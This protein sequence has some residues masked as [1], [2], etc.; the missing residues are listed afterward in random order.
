MPPPHTSTVLPTTL[1]MD[2]NYGGTPNGAEG[3]QTFE[4]ARWEAENGGKG[5]PAGETK[6]VR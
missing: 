2:G 6:T 5:E 1:G 3:S 4:F